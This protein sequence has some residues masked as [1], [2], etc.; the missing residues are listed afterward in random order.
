[1]FDTI[2][3]VGLGLMGGSLALALKEAG[4]ADKIIGIDRDDA[5]LDAALA[6]SAV[7]VAGGGLEMAGEANV[8]VLATPVRTI[9]RQL[10]LLGE[11]A[12][13]GTLIMDLGSTKQQIVSAMDG[14]P[15]RLFSVGGH[16]MCGKETSGLKA[17]EAALYRGKLFVLTPTAHSSEASLAAATGLAQAAGAHVL[18]MEAER[19]DRIVAAMSHL[20][21]VVASNLM[22]TVDGWAQGEDGAWSLAASGFRDTTRL[23]ASD[24]EMMLDIL[25]TNSE[26]VADLMRRYSRH[27]ATLADLIYDEDEEALRAL[28]EAAAQKRRELSNRER[29]SATGTSTAQGDLL[30]A[31]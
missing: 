29:K 28:L 23:A 25:L 17:A 27:F 1:M 13:D 3:I 30:E 19:H 22:G 7:D 11:I 5:T 18:V 21:F 14:L 31:N 4:A 26:N 20:P 24:A 15:A 2:A 6:C 9:L 16:P 8:V 10:P 12:A